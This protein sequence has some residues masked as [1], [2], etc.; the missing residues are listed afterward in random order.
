[1]TRHLKIQTINLEKLNVFK[2]K[3]A[4]DYLAVPRMEMIGTC[5]P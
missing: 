2:G 3:K 5:S 1:M 4:E